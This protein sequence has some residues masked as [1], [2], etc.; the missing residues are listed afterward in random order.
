[1]DPQILPYILKYNLHPN[2]ICTSFADFL[3]EKKS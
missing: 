1:M 2:L 3:N